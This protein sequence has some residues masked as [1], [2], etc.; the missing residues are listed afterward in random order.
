MGIPGAKSSLG[1]KRMSSDL[2]EFN[3]TNLDIYLKAQPTNVQ[4][5]AGKK[6]KKGT[7][8]DT[9][10]II[11]QPLQTVHFNIS[12]VQKMMLD[13]EKF[14]E[15]NMSTCHAFK[16]NISMYKGLTEQLSVPRT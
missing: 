14:L 1:I 15:I 10:C 9:H 7:V 4:K 3:S 2:D 6:K 11:E 12:M 5:A 16:K 8:G 13:M